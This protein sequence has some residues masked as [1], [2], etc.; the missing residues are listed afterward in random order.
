[1]TSTIP[2]AVSLRGNFTFNLKN[3]R[4]EDKTELRKRFWLIIDSAQDKERTKHIQHPCI[5]CLFTI[6]M[7][8]EGIAR[9]AT[10]FSESES[11]LI[12]LVC[13]L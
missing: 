6:P 2:M 4:R 12:S 9:G 10:V 1:M 3:I 11:V 13:H 8:H 5:S 7:I